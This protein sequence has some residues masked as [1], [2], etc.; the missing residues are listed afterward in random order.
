MRFSRIVNMTSNAENESHAS[1]ARRAIV[2][3]H[4]S[5]HGAWC[6]SPLIPLL[7]AKGITAVAFDLS[8]Y[9]TGIFASG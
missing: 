7:S 9:G 8:G 2:L 6:Y 4:G 1:N 5:W 3:V